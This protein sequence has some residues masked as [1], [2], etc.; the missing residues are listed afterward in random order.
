MQLQIAGSMLTSAQS[1]Y[2]FTVAVVGGSVVVTFQEQSVDGPALA[3]GLFLALAQALG[4]RE[5]KNRAN[6]IAATPTGTSLVIDG[7]PATQLEAQAFNRNLFTLT[8][9]NDD[10]ADP[11]V[12]IVGSVAV[13]SAGFGD[14][15][16][17][18]K[19][20]PGIEPNT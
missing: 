7:V 3:E 11:R 12:A 20:V 8:Y 19:T 15:T 10:A 6:I 4:T 9:P 5:A 16:R 2:R 14:F 13:V 18:Q 17:A 1:P